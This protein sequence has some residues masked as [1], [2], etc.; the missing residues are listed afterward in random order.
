MLDHA[1]KIAKALGYF[2][3]D[4][5]P[6]EA[7]GQPSLAQASTTDKTE[8]DKNRKRFEF[9]H[10][11]RTDCLF[12]LSFGKPTLIAPGSWKVNFPDPT[13]DG[14]DDE[15]SRFIQIHFLASMRLTLVVM[16][17]LDWI[18]SGPDPDPVLHDATIDS[19]LDEVQLIMS[20][21]DTDE[22]L[23]I[24]KTQFDTWFCVDM[25]FSS[26]KVL[27]VLHQSKICDQERH[28]LPHQTV[29][30]SRKSIQMFQS[31]LGSSLHAYW[32]ISLI[33][34]HQFIPFFILCLDIIGNPEHGDIETDLTSVTWI[35]DYVEKMVEER[36]EL[37]PV[38]I[39][40]K[41]VI[42]ACRQVKTNR[43][44][45]LMTGNAQTDC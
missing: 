24:A 13:I 20:D 42:F 7:D 8:I 21:W 10:L 31:L 26:Y 1:C 35:S 12:R 18:D 43:L 41:A 44:A 2:S 28:R 40:M 36:A 5:N 33:L 23:R 25:I 38:M 9:W 16:K 15:S 29:D 27:I 19:F 30:I 3:V 32:G 37:R 14:V 45:S 39:I 17:Y 11:L 4:G 6:E 22:L 34:L